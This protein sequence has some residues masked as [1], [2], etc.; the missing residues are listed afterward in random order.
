MDDSEITAQAGMMVLGFSLGGKLCGFEIGR[1]QEVL[2]M[3]ELT[4]VPDAPH[5]MA[6]ALNLRGAVLPVL[7]LA[8]LL[9]LPVGH[10]DLETPIVVVRSGDRRVGLIVD[11]VHDVVEFPA[12]DVDP[13]TEL[14]PL[15]RALSGVARTDKGL[16]ML[17]DLSRVL[18]LAA[19]VRDVDEGGDAHG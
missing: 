16:M 14:F 2:Q 18:E 19:A 4:E 8:T 9:G 11:D 15:R 1:V 17:F 3:V 7:D 5:Y 12:E 13:P 6:G 10:Y